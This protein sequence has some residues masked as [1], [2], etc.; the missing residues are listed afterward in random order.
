M[1]VIFGAL[2][3]KKRYVTHL[4]LDNNEKAIENVFVEFY[5]KN[6]SKFH[7]HWMGCQIKHR[8][9]GFC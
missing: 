3:E 4:P 8:I 6:R 1:V 5:C 7:H 9:V 2:Q